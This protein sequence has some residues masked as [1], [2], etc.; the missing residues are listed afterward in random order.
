[1]DAHTFDRWTVAF[2]QRRSRRSTVRQLAGGL[3]GGLLASRG[4][5]PVRA[6]DD[7]DQDQLFD[8]D[9]LN[10]YGTKPNNPDTDGDQANDGLEIWNRDQGLGDPNDPLVP[11]NPAAPPPAEAPPPAA[12]TCIALGGECVG[13]DLPCCG[14]DPALGY[15]NVLC[16]RDLTGAGYCTDVTGRFLCPDPGVPT[17]GCPVGQTNCGGF[18]TD[19]AIDHGNCGW[20]GNQCKE[21][22]G[23]GYNCVNGSCVFYCLPGLVDCGGYC[24]DLQTDFRNCGACFNH[25]GFREYGAGTCMGGECYYPTSFEGPPATS[26][27]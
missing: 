11:D 17:T 27:L 23:P 1:M 13:I 8:D 22:G 21:V 7:Q 24:T 12:P 26:A 5:V 18:C 9:E 3:L 20:C 6:Q 19:L 4:S 25:C 10:V 16:C 15:N 14:N 2:A